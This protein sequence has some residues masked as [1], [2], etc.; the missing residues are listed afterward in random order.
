MGRGS[1]LCFPDLPL[2]WGLQSVSPT[3]GR[4]GNLWGCSRP[5]LCPAASPTGCL[6]T[7]F[8]SKSPKIHP[9]DESHALRAAEPHPGSSPKSTLD[10]TPESGCPPD[11]TSLLHRPIEDVLESASA[12]EQTPTALRAT[13]ADGGGACPH[14]PL[15]LSCSS[16]SESLLWIRSDASQPATG[17]RALTPLRGGQGSLSAVDPSAPWQASLPA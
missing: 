15:S 1:A 9:Q 4:A 17:S 3:G 2:L 7:C 8:L 10:C 13:E 6:F 12:P 14:P 11:T 5:H 16:G